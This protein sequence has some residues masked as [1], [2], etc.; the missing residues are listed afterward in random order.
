MDDHFNETQQQWKSGSQ[1]TEQRLQKQMDISIQEY[2]SKVQVLK[3][4]H[5]KFEN[6]NEELKEEVEELKSSK[7]LM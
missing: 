3:L 7:E 2:E 5:N 6:E 1:Q 4:S